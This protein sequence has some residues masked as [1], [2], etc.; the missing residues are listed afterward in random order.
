VNFEVE[1][2]EG[3]EEE[4]EEEE[5]EEEEAVR[6]RSWQTGNGNVTQHKMI[7]GGFH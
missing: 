6:T 5:E 1:G 7:G 2:E 3:E 4:G